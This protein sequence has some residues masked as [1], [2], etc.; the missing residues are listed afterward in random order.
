ME[1]EIRKGMSLFLNKNNNFNNSTNS[2][3]KQKIENIIQ[4][5][6]SE[7]LVWKS[8]FWE[9]AIFFRNKTYNNEFLAVVLSSLDNEDFFEIYFFKSD[10]FGNDAKFNNDIEHYISFRVSKLNL[11]ML[12]T[13]LMCNSF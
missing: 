12:R 9:E 2:M 7:K 5:F 4:E 8:E 10:W 3:V 1:N 6:Y 11:E 13:I